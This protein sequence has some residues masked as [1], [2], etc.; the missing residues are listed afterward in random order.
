MTTVEEIVTNAHRLVYRK[1]WTAVNEAIGHADRPSFNTKKHVLDAFNDAYTI[2]EAAIWILDDYTAQYAGIDWHI[3]SEMPCDLYFDIS[4]R[5]HTSGKSWWASD[6]CPYCE[7][8]AAIVA[9]IRG[10]RS[11]PNPLRLVDPCAIERGDH[12]GASDE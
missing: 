6:H 10:T 8:R 7:E 1:A 11:T 4:D 12:L 3:L 9:W 5:P 2:R